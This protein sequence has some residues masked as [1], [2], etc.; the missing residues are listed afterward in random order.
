MSYKLTEELQVMTLKNDEKSD[1]E[2]TCPFKIDIR[3]FTNFDP[4]TRKSHQKCTFQW[5]A[6]D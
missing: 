4:R 5:A 3:N 6:F 1:E 2:L